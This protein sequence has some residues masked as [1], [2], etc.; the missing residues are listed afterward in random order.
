MDTNLLGETTAILAALMWTTCSIL[1]A[2]AGKRIG[3]LSV[4]SIRILMALAF[5]ST[6]HLLFFGTIIPD[7]N[8]SQW[9][10]ISLS[11]IIGLALGDMGY[12]GVLVILGPRKGI[13]LM[14]MA[15]IFSTIS[16]YFILDEVLGIWT[17]IG[18]AVTLTG[19]IIVIIER[20]EEVKGN[21]GNH[22]EN[23]LS[24]RIKIYGI[25][26]GLGGAIGQGIGLV[27]SKYGMYVG[28]NNNDALNS[29][30]VSLIR[31]LAATILIWM[32]V[33][34]SG[35]FKDVKNAV[36]DKIAMK[37]TFGGA[38]SG[39]F[40][41]VWLSMVAITYTVAG[42]AATLMA[43]APVMIIPVVWIVYK[44]KTNW[45][46]IIGAIIAVVGVAILFLN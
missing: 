11:G 19:V 35:R 31:M 3:A 37:R 23:A 18:I 9:F 33:I 30:S 46:G 2:S 22:K 32:I 14:S 15:P 16:A 10:Y 25:L 17:I 39:P 24:K 44:E 28:T 7:A 34:F 1:F 41:G 45:R 38:F 42:V 21:G 12:F 27:V 29:L 13:L 4:N 43:L 5:L 6:A 20:D 40:L 36:K 26:L 8:Q